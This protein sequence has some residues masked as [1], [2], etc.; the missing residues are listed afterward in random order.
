MKAEDYSWFKGSAL[1]Y[2]YCMTFVQ[3][4]D[5]SEALRRIDGKTHHCGGR[6]CCRSPDLALGELSR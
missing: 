1:S 5:R 6:M 3:G 4:L 2:G